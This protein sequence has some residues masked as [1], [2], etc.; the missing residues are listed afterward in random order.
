M[1]KAIKKGDMTAL[2]DDFAARFGNAEV[3]KSLDAIK[4]SASSSL[5]APG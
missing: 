1:N 2:V 4:T 3:S 5:P